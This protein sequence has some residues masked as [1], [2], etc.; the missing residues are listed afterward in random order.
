MKAMVPTNIVLGF[1]KCGI[2]PFNPD[3][4]VLGTP[5]ADHENS[6]TEETTDAA[7]E[8]LSGIEQ[9]SED[10]IE[11][12]LEEEYRFER[13]YEEGYDLYDPRYIV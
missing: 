5:D 11:F 1:R 9:N 7:E 13:R 3:A 2:Y 6:T 12:T 10:V 8:D 4:I